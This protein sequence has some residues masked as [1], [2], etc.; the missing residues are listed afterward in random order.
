MKNKVK[1]KKNCIA[2]VLQVQRGGVPPPGAA[3]GVCGS[4]DRGAGGGDGCQRHS[5]HGR[6]VL[7][8]GPLPVSVRGLVV[9][10]RNTKS[11]GT[12]RER[13]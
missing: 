6:R 5:Q 13:L 3:A 1:L 4:R 8:Q 11:T 9:P 10:G 12:C 7:W 2:G